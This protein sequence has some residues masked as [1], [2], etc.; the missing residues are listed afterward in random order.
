MVKANCRN[1]PKVSKVNLNKSMILSKLIHGSQGYSPKF[2][3][4]KTLENVLKK[5]LKWVTGQSDYKKSAR[6]QAISFILTYLIERLNLSKLMSK[7]LNNHYDCDIKTFL[8]LISLHRNTR[9]TKPLQFDH[10]LPKVSSPGP[11]H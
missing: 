9:S 4:L 11:K 1:V 3:N 7:L 10:K 2:A 5:A 8:H 6:V